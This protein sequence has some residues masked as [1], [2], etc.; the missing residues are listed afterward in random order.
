MLQIIMNSTSGRLL[1]YRIKF[2]INFIER[3]L[4]TSV[5][6]EIFMFHRLLL[7]ILIKDLI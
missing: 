6:L 7:V 4:L 1:I 3:T 2:V 5:I